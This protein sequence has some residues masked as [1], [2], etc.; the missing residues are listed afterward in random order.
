MGQP[1]LSI[2]EFQTKIELG[3]TIE[4]DCNKV[5]QKIDNALQ[6]AGCTTRVIQKP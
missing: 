6:S 4:I 1:G 2:L 3:L 5:T